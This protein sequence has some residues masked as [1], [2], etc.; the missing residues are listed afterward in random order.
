MFHILSIGRKALTNA[1]QNLQTAGHNIANVNTEGYSRQRVVQVSSDANSDSLHYYGTGVEAV[2]IERMRDLYLDNNFREENSELG[3]WSR[4]AEKL[5]ELESELNELGDYGLA[6]DLNA[7]WD[8]WESLSDNPMDN[9]FRLDLL[10]SAQSLSDSFSR[11]HTTIRDKYAEVDKEIRD[12]AST[13]NGIGDQLATLNMQIQQAEQ[14][15]PIPNDLLDKWDKLLDDLSEYGNVRVN[16]H[17]DGSRVVYFGS[18]QLVSH[19]SSRHLRTYTETEDGLD[20][21]KLVWDD[22]NTGINGLQTG[23]LAGLTNLRDN[24][25]TSYMEKLD[26]LAVNLAQQLNAIHR[27]GSGLGDPPSTNID[28]FASDIT[29]AADFRLSDEIAA[30]PDKI[31]ASLGGEEGD[32]RVAL[33]I[34]ALRSDATMGNQSFG[35]YYGSM[36][37]SIGRDSSNAANQ[38][39]MLEL[40]A[41]QVDNYRESVKGV[42]IDEES[43]NLLSYQRSYQAAAKIVEMADGLLGTIMGIVR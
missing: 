7:F 4:S 5:S 32:N 26:N 3:Y 35:E 28:F 43:V 39:D 25:L 16:Y 6:V 14:T 33:M 2:R 23:Q 31:A 41:T 38:S 36:L 1:E 30:S 18:D 29:G 40:T 22:T 9:T 13:V 34:N 19:D 24:Q 20:T 11:V 42:S 37:S 17:D 27:Q 12:I 21:T 10:E 15:G 8:S